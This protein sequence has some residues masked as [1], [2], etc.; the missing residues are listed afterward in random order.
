MG[1]GC[2]KKIFAVVHHTNQKREKKLHT[3]LTKQTNKQK[4]K[5]NKL[6]RG[7]HNWSN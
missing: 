7:D 1:F 3:Q 4:Q 6:W 5:T 2:A